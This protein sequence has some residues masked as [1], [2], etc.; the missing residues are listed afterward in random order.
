MNSSQIITSEFTTACD[1]SDELQFEIFRGKTGLKSIRDDWNR[2]TQKS[3]KLR[4][5]QCYE[6]HE[7]YLGTLAEARSSACYVMVRRRGSPVG[8]IPL[9]QSVRKIAGL[10]FRSLE[11]IH[12][13][14]IP[15]SDGVFA[16]S[17]SDGT[18]LR[19]LIARL[20]RQSEIT[21]D[22]LIF[23]E[24]LEDSCLQRALTASPIP[25]LISTPRTR[26]NYIP[27]ISF[28]ELSSKFS[29]NFRGNLRK[30]RNKLMNLSGVEFV[31]VRRQP[32]LG[33]ALDEFLEVEASGWKGATGRQTAIKLDA[34]LINFY[35]SLCETFSPIDA[36][37]IN[38]L[39]ANGN[40]IAGQFCLVVGD[41][42][43]ILKIGYDESYA[44]IAPGNMLLEYSLRRYWREGVVKYLNLVTGAP[45]HDNWNPLSYAVSNA[46]VF[47]ATPAGLAAFTLMRCENYLRGKYKARLKPVLERRR[48]FRDRHSLNGGSGSNK[49]GDKESA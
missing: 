4:F 12:H 48:N 3:D 18:I 16:R 29:K 27:C 10:R 32:Q 11:L 44:H 2:L 46:Y 36:C 42:S 30:A 20:Q 14:H 25:R 9:M 34:R 1:W 49:S 7:S 47:N 41:T 28:D 13:S 31:S 23:P 17:D 24:L 33:Q 35:R 45:W 40:C 21:W 43:Y 15:L 5:F 19:G 8:V 22:L 39:K 26:C 6:W 38:L 37:E